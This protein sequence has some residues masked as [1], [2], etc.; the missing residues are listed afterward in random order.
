[1][2]INTSK[3]LFVIFPGQS[4]GHPIQQNSLGMHPQNLLL[5]AQRPPVNGLNMQNHMGIPPTSAPP[6][7]SA[8][9]QS[10]LPETAITNAAVSNMQQHL[11]FVGANFSQS[12]FGQ[13]QPQQQKQISSPYGNGQQQQFS[14]SNQT[15]IGKTQQQMPMNNYPVFQG[16]E[17]KDYNPWKDQQAPQPPVNWWGN[18]SMASQILPQQGTVKDISMN[19]DAFQNWANSSN[20]AGQ[21]LS[22]MP[23]QPGNNYQQNPHQTRLFNGRNNFEE[24][25]S[26]DVSKFFSSPNLRG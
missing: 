17:T 18:N 14:F 3:I 9:Y 22:N 26:F 19:T 21:R 24:S 25:R 23:V 10:S 2:L 13:L 8:T 12:N 5:N 4:I 20:S 1:M 16:Y 15:N 11:N 7:L 6:N